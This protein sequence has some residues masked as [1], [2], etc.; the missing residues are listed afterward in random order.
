MFIDKISVAKTPMYNPYVYEKSIHD[1]PDF[2]HPEAHELEFRKALCV[3][4]H[5]TTAPHVCFNGN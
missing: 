4:E 2:F 5:S 1:L 3:C